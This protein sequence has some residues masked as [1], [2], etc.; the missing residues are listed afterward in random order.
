MSD[1]KDI[2]YGVAL[3]A[4]WSWTVMFLV[5][6][7]LDFFAKLFWR[8]SNCERNGYAPLR[9]D[10]EDFYTRRAYYRL[11]DCFNRP[12]AG[13]PDRVMDVVLRSS[14]KG[15]EP[16][17]NTDEVRRC[18]NLGSYNYLGF[19]NKDAYCTPRC[20][21]TMDSFA[22]STC[23]SRENGGTLPVHIELEATV[24][25]FLDQE[26]AMIVGMGYA[27]N[28][29]IIPV[30][31]GKGDLIISDALNHASIVAG[32]R[33]S[34]ARV[35]IFKHNNPRHL[36][37]VVRQAIA[38][39]QPRTHRPWNKI[40]IVIEGIYSMEGEICAL[41]EIVE[42]KKKYKAYLYLDEAHSIGALGSGGRGACEQVGVR[43]RDVDLLMGTF[44]KSY[45]SCGGYIAGSAE[46]IGHLKAHTAAHQMATS[47]SPIAAEQVLSAFKLIT[48]EDGSGRG[49][50]KIRQLKANSNYFRWHLLQ[51]GFHV[52]GDWDS[53]VMPIM[54]YM[55]GALAHFSRECL[56]RHVA[57]VV[58]GFPATPL[59][60]AR[61]RIC[62]S[63]AHTRSD[64]D[65]ALRV[66]REVGE[67]T[68]C[69]FRRNLPKSL[70]SLES[71]VK[72]IGHKAAATAD[73]VTHL[74]S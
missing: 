57:V 23:A 29:A 55:P 52:L 15:T 68:G 4:Y 49:L 27:T 18:I 50:D 54:V 14:P 32:V 40:V 43:F 9:Q 2:P 66:L 16:L 47:M 19:A 58:V 44:T 13:P 36:E 22:V 56:K 74:I 5:G 51:M 10:Y 25:N 38:E 71:V 20:Q 12:V 1:L 41:R 67:Q 26:A 34:G 59:L 69:L 3:S 45:G 24:A 42:V 8:R 62:I 28:A 64:L 60:T 39:G 63:A 6:H 73:A 72:E 7:M 65:F 37:Q 30:F 17:I 53:P 11:V 35:K 61:A 21:Q 33:G 48:G 31:C 46:A 70:P